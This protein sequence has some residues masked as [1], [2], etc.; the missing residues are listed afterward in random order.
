[1]MLQTKD[2]HKQFAHYF[3]SK[4]LEP[5][6]YL[7]VKKLN[8]GHICIDLRQIDREELEEAGYKEIAPI[9]R[10]KSAKMVA[11][12][13]TDEPFVYFN[14]RLYLQRYFKYENSVFNRIQALIEAGKGKLEQQKSALIEIS[15]LVG[16]LFPSQNTETDWQ[17]VAALSAVLNQFS[18]ITGG[19][20][21]GKTTTVAKVLTLLYR[22]N[23]DLKIALAAPTGKAAARMAESLKNARDLSAEV[24]SL[25]GSLEP[26]TIHRLLGYQ[27]NSLYFKHH[28]SNPL[29]FD[30]IILDESSMIDIALFSKLLE[31]VSDETKLILLGDKDQLASVEAGSLFGDL[32]L[33]Q[34]QLNQFNAER[35]EFFNHFGANL[36]SNKAVE[37]EHLLFQH[38][39]ELQV[40]H[41]FKDDGGIG[42]LS[43]AIINNQPES[44]LE[45]YNREDAQ[46]RMDEVYSEEILDSVA[47]SYRAYIEEENINEALKKLNQVRV[48]CATR[49]GEE[50]LY[51]LNTRIQQKLQEKGL[52]QLNSE[53][54]N[55]R[56]IMVLSNNYDLGLFNGDIGIVREERKGDEIVKRVWFEGKE[57]ELKSVLASFL[58]SVETVFAMTIHK[59]QGSEFVRVLVVMPQLDDMPILTRELLYTA[60][61]RAKSEV[62]V[63]GKRETILNCA[64]KQ[65]KRGSGIVE[66]FEIRN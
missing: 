48:L 36:D 59:S 4:E 2:P 26:L 6:L 34:S 51:R 21:T 61:T 35:I 22:L 53:F 52:I 9:E 31:A 63:Q 47:E 11:H 24:K 57:G 5:Y 10:L 38:I 28:A 16:E 8:E 17:M 20:G 3:R 55:H 62:I 32:C 12:N 49:E 40:S 23:P 64:Q 18:I 54:Y 15:D 45:F 25:I 30:I 43:K 1:M 14:D 42:K 7:L 66:R 27:K 44:I 60:V 56:P 29:N 13:Q 33:A 41:R 19:P 50:G 37:S 65:V 46:V 39:V 58:E